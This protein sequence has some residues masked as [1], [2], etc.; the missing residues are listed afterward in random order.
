M[1]LRTKV[2]LAII[3]CWSIILGSTY[4]GAIKILEKSYSALEDK[5]IQNNLSL[6]NE[7][8]ENLK[9]KNDAVIATWFNWDTLYEYMATPSYELSNDQNKNFFNDL[10]TP[11]AL[12][13]SNVDLYLVFDTNGNLIYGKALNE[14]KTVVNEPS[15]ETLQLFTSKGEF[16]NIIIP[17][18]DSS[19]LILTSKGI[20]VLSAHRILPT[21][22][23]GVSRGTGI[24][25]TY[26]TDAIWN[27]VS[28]DSKLDL[29]L[30]PLSNKNQLHD[31]N[32]ILEEALQHQFYKLN[33]DEDNLKI[34]TLLKD[35]N[36]KPIAIIQVIAKHN[37]LLLGLQTIRYFNFAFVLF[38]LF[39]AFI[40]FYQ[41]SYLVINRLDRI[42]NT[43]TQIIKT[44]NFTLK[45]PEKGKDEISLLT[46]ETNNLLST[47]KEI[48]SHLNDIINFMPSSIL[49]V[50]NEFVVTNLNELALK[51][52]HLLR[53][54]A[55]NKNLFD[56]YPFLIDY[57]ESFEKSLKLKTLEKVNN[58]V[59]VHNKK[60]YHAIIYPLKQS[61]DAS[62]SVRLD[63]I[64]ENMQIETSLIE[65]ERLSAIG[66]LTAGFAHEI[67]NPVNFITSSINPL[68]KDLQILEVIWK[69]YQELKNND[70][71]SILQNKIEIIE[72]F[73]KEVDYDY[74]IE[75]IM[76]LVD[77]TVEGI[78]RT[79]EIT[80]DL[81]SYANENKSSFKK[82]DIE[83]NIDTTISLLKP[84][85]KNKIVITTQ[86]GK[87]P[88]IEG[89][90]SKLNQVFMN[91]IANAIDAIIPKFGEIIIKT[92]KEGDY[93]KIFIKDNGV[94]ISDSNITKI[95]DPFFTTK[96][97]GK[98]TGLGLSITLSI[99]Q[100]HS[101][102]IEV[103]SKEGKGAEFI[104][105]L[106]ITHAKQTVSKTTENLSV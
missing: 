96:S 105:T 98:G 49:I 24:I 61:N 39:F 52:L 73:K 58:I 36:E 103:I 23:E 90:S 83:K 82:M 25:G 16:W 15:P 3:F 97:V 13:N 7:A 18:H 53:A 31:F 92:K 69:K 67:N 86:Y 21:I 72:K 51:E 6:V 54:K 50:N 27:K 81:K 46:K 95:F 59:D 80:K 104:I 91:V 87:I 84:N 63:D 76:Q 106:P 35:I 38:G 29:K 19:G 75:E 100:D 45:I 62:L 11:G 9:A 60:H 43:I 94:G 33:N 42:K 40:L 5:R 71:D 4:F 28:A 89:I 1:K 64:T 57:K 56:L 85:F 14:N 47:V 10:I 22:G 32:L 78:R 79:N 70:S 37:L 34:Y 66:V 20:L 8:I 48:E 101:G 12:N 77:G 2:I 99:V 44:K 55:I 68:K 74:V 30:F 65:H 26:L 17:S 93:V 102:N 41:F 88:Q